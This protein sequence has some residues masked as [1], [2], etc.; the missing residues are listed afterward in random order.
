MQLQLKLL[1][2]KENFF[3]RDGSSN[4]N[5]VTTLCKI[6][7]TSA[8]I[9]TEPNEEQSENSP[10]AIRVSFEPSSNVSVVSDR[11]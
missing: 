9:T 5:S 2:G 4:I 8:G 1:E 11:Q 6:I 7:S 3:S 10:I